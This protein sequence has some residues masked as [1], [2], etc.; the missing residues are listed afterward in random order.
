MF[1]VAAIRSPRKKTGTAGG[2]GQR[3]LCAAEHHTLALLLH[4]TTLS[5]GLEA[6]SLTGAHQV[7]L[8][9]K[10]KQLKAN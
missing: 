8:G 5:P 3:N 1:A 2:K 10:L 7:N 9:Q 6:W 4:A